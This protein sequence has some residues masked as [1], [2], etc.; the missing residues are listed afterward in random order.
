MDA[1]TIQVTLPKEILLSL[2]LSNADAARAVKKF[3]VLQLVRDGRISVGKGAEFLGLAKYEFVELMA[4][5]GVA[6]F[7]YTPGELAEELKNING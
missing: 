6:Y 4:A 1:V 2:G 5:E 3:L 7:N